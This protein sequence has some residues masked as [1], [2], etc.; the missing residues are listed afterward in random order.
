MYLR[1]G[2]NLWIIVSHLFPSNPQ[3]SLRITK[4]RVEFKL[5]HRRLRPIVTIKSL[6]DIAIDESNFFKMRQ[7]TLISSRTSLSP[8]QIRHDDY[9][10]IKIWKYSK[11]PPSGADLHE[12]LGNQKGEKREKWSD[13]DPRERTWSPLCGPNIRAN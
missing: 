5:S 12:I 11:K 13:F 2:S 4:L 9:R 1:E 3:G 8:G 6:V 10:E 7:R